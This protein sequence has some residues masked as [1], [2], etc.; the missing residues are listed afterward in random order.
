MDLDAKMLPSMQVDFSISSQE[1]KAEEPWASTR[2]PLRSWWEAV[3]GSYVAILQVWM[4]ISGWMFQTALS[5]PSFLCTNPKWCVSYCCYEYTHSHMVIQS[6]YIIFVKPVTASFH[7]GAII[8]ACDGW[9]P[10]WWRWY[11]SS[12]SYKRSLFHESGSMRKRIWMSNGASLHWACDIQWRLHTHIVCCYS[13]GGR[14]HWNSS[15]IST[16]KHMRKRCIPSPCGS[17]L[18]RMCRMLGDM[19]DTC[20]CDESILCDGG[21]ALQPRSGV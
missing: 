15:C 18:P 7:V 12:S 19:S 2:N 21:N 6:H 3:N 13:T 17:C 9:R 20:R 11:V 16:K 8:V 1:A 14:L 5:S 4:I 10:K